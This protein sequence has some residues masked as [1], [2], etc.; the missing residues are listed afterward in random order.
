MRTKFFEPRN[1]AAFIGVSRQRS[2]RQQPMWP[3]GNE[4]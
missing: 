4:I 1:F 2:V 3:G